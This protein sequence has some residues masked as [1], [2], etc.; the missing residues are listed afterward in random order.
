MLQALKGGGGG[1]GV[2]GANTSKA[3][4]VQWP[5]LCCGY[6]FC[7]AMLAAACSLPAFLVVQLVCLR[8]VR[9]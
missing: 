8:S 1:V 9:K 6:N 3:I 2:K 4:S 7:I 5:Y